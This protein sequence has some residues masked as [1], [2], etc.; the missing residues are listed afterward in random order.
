MPGEPVTGADAV[1]ATFD[2]V[3]EGRRERG[4]V[5][6]ATGWVRITR[7]N[8][9]QI[10]LR[11]PPESLLGIWRARRR[12]WRCVRTQPGSPP[13]HYVRGTGGLTELRMVRQP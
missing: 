8:P 1:L 7:I 5:R 2:A 9:L 13:L 4:R 11:G 10:I 3:A 6:T 12:H